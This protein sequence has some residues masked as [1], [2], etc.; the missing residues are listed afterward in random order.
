MSKT[1]WYDELTEIDLKDKIIG[2]AI[3]EN[4][5]DYND[6]EIK[7]KKTHYF[8]SIEDAKHILNYTFDNG[9]QM[10]QEILAK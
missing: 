8:K 5:D 7:N 9:Y 3:C 10:F 4:E 1:N 6:E 2:I